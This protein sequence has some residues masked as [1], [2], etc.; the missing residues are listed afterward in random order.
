LRAVW[1]GEI[2]QETVKSP[3]NYSSDETL[4]GELA[5]VF[6]NVEWRPHHR[7]LLQGGAMLEHHYFTGA[8]ISPRAAV[9]FTVAPG[10][11]VRLGV[12]QA[13][14]SP[15]F[16]EEEGNLVYLLESGGLAD[17]FT[18]PSPGLEPERILSREI[19]YVGF[20]RSAGLEFDV[21][22]FQDKINDYIAQQKG[23]FFPDAG[24]ILS[25]NEFQYQNLG[26]VKS[27]GGEVQLRWKPTHALDVSAH[28]ARVTVE[29]S[30]TRQN[31]NEDIPL[32]APSE[33]WGL[34]A[35]Y[36]VGDGWE[37][38]LGAWRTDPVKWLTEG[39]L[40]RAYTRVDAR[41]ARRWT[42]QGREVEAA[43]VGQNLGDDY[44]E[45]RDT[46]VF[47]SRVYGSLAFA[48]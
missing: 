15:T 42:W 22:V 11:V 12:S 40:T 44:E 13:Y 35:T 28:Y 2:R 43:L 46:N 4:S 20:W 31:Y 3:Q 29:A 21:R 19:G 9:N 6:G 8:D 17:V 34:L 5:R 48:W 41:L 26:S 30:T 7:V 45:F 1:G 27:W 37:A 23:D 14:R 33:S 36:R 38:S 18:V 16:F 47:S 32:S 25:A 24:S 39:D 10:H